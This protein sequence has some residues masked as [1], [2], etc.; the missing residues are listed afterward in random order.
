MTAAMACRC[1]SCGV[2]SRLRATGRPSDGV[3]AVGG[4]VL[5]RWAWRVTYN[6]VPGNLTPTEFRVLGVLLERPGRT[7]QHAE[8]LRRIWGGEQGLAEADRHILR[9]VATRLRDQL[10]RVGVPRGAIENVAGVGYR[11]DR[12]ALA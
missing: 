3:L 10:A 7:V 4:L 11:F 2:A 1:T 9:V 12:E 6:G 8:L 5:D